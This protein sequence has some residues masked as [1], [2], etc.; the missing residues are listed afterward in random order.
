MANELSSSCPQANEL[1]D[2]EK[3]EGEISLDDVSSSEEGQPYNPSKG[4]ANCCPHCK[5][6]KTCA[7]WCGNLI[8]YHINIKKGA[9]L[10]G[11]ENRA[12]HQ[13][14]LKES[15]SFP[16]SIGKKSSQC[17][18]K[19]QKK[20]ASS[21]DASQKVANDG[22]VP[23]SSDSDLD[24]DELKHDETKK[25]SSSKKKHKKRRKKSDSPDV[26]I[27]LLVKESIHKLEPKKEPTKE[28]RSRPVAGRHHSPER[29]KPF[30]WHHTCPATS[31]PKRCPKSP[32][33]VQTSRK[34]CSPSR[35]RKSSRKSVSLSPTDASDELPPESPSSRGSVTRLLKKVRRLE[36]FSCKAGDKGSSLKDKLSGI[37][38]TETTEIAKAGN[39]DEDELVNNTKVSKDNDSSAEVV[40]IAYIV[41]S[42]PVEETVDE[43]YPIIEISKKNEVDKDEKAELPRP[44]KKEKTDLVVKA[45]TPL[46]PMPSVSTSSR[47]CSPLRPPDV[48]PPPS[49]SVKLPNFC[50]DDNEEDLELRMIALR[51]AVLKKH[52]TRMQ[53]S[54]MLKKS[55][56]QKIKSPFDSSF[57]QDFV[58]PADACYTGIMVDCQDD[59]YCPEDMDLD[60]DLELDKELL[61]M[62]QVELDWAPSPTDEIA[63]Q[64]LM[65]ENAMNAP[66]RVSTPKREYFVNQSL[67]SPTNPT[68]TPCSFKDFQNFERI[69]GP[70]LSKVTWDVS[71][72]GAND[73]NG[74][75]Y[76]LTNPTLRPYSPTDMTIY[77]PDLPGVHSTD[78]GSIGTS[79]SL[80]PPL[81]PPPMPPISIMDVEESIMLECPTNVLT[82]EFVKPMAPPPLP[83]P[84]LLDNFAVVSQQTLTPI[85]MTTPVLSFATPAVP[86]VPITSALVNDVSSP[87]SSL[88]ELLSG[89]TQTVSDPSLPLQKHDASVEC[90]FR[91]QLAISQQPMPIEADN[92]GET[93]LDGSPLVSMEKNTPHSSS[94]WPLFSETHCLSRNTLKVTPT[95]ADGAAPAFE[96]SSKK[97][98]NLVFECPS[99]LPTASKPKMSNIFKSTRVQGVPKKDVA[100]SPAAAFNG[101]AHDD[102]VEE[103]SD[104]QP[105][106]QSISERLKQLSKNKEQNLGAKLR[107]GKKRK[108][109]VVPR[110]PKVTIEKKRAASQSL[111]NA[112]M[113]LDQAHRRKE[114][115]SKSSEI[116]ECQQQQSDKEIEVENE[117]KKDIEDDEETL[118][119]Q[120]LA[121]LTKRLNK[122]VTT[123]VV[124]KV[125]EKCSVTTPAKSIIEKL[126]DSRTELAKMT[127]YSVATKRPMTNGITKNITSIIP[128]SIKRS[129]NAQRESLY[130]LAQQNLSAATKP[131]S[132]ITNTQD[133]SSETSLELMDSHVDQR[134]VINEPKEKIKKIE[135]SVEQ[136]L[137]NIRQQ[138]EEAAAKNISSPNQVSLSD[139]LKK[140]VTSNSNATDG[141]NA[142]VNQTIDLVSDATTASTADLS[143][144]TPVIFTNSSR[145]TTT[146]NSTIFT[147]ATAT[148]ATVRSS[149]EK[150]KITANDFEKLSLTATPQAVKHLPPSLQ[151]EYRRLKQQIIERERLKLQKAKEAATTTS[152]DSTFIVSASVTTTSAPLGSCKTPT[153]V[154][155]VSQVFTSST[156]TV[157][158]VSTTAKTNNTSISFFSSSSSLTPN[159]SPIFTLNPPVTST[160]L[161]KQVSLRQNTMISETPV[162]TAA[163]NN[164]LK[165]QVQV[166]ISTVNKLSMVEMSRKTSPRP[167]TATISK[168]MVDKNNLIN[169]VAS[170]SSRKLAPQ[171]QNCSG[172][173]NLSKE[174]AALLDKMNSVLNSQKKQIS[175]V[176]QKVSTLRILTKDQINLKTLQVPSKISKLKTCTPTDDSTK[177]SQNISTTVE[178]KSEHE[179]P[180]AKSAKE[181][182]ANVVDKSMKNQDSAHL[183]KAIN[184]QST[185]KNL[186]Q[187]TIDQS[188][189]MNA[190]PSTEKSTLGWT[191]FKDLVDDEVDSLF[192]LPVMKQKQLLTESEEKLI[193]KRHSV[194]DDITEMSGSL[195]QWEIERDLQNT[196]TQEIQKLREQL[197]MAEGKL[198]QQKEKVN[199]IQPKVSMYHEKINNGRKECFRLSKVC[200]SLGQTIFGPNYKVPTA[201]AELLNNRIK[202]VATHTQ[203]LKS[204]A[205]RSNLNRHPIPAKMKSSP[206]CR[207]NFSMKP[208]V[209]KSQNSHDSHLNK[210][211]IIDDV[212]NFVNDNLALIDKPNVSNINNPNQMKTESRTAKEIN[213][214]SLKENN[215]IIFDGKNNNSSTTLNN[216]NN[217]INESVEGV[218]TKKINGKVSMVTRRVNS[219]STDD[220]NS[221][222]LIQDIPRKI[223]SK[224]RSTFDNFTKS[225]T[226]CSNTN[227]KVRSGYALSNNSNSEY[228]VNIKINHPNL[229]NRI[230]DKKIFQN[231]TTNGVDN[232]KLPSN[233]SNND[234]HLNDVVDDNMEPVCSKERLSDE[235]ASVTILDENLESTSMTYAKNNQIDPSLSKTAGLN[236]MTENN[237][238]S[239]KSIIECTAD[240]SDSNN[241]NVISREKNVVN[242]VRNVIVNSETD[243]SAKIEHSTFLEEISL[244]MANTIQ[245]P[246]NIHVYDQKKPHNYNRILSKQIMGCNDEL[247]N[248]AVMKKNIVQPYESILKHL[249]EPRKKNIDGILCPYELIGTCNDED[250]QF[251][252]LSAS[253]CS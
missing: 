30:L 215:I 150:E 54:G 23:I 149:M 108:K 4:L 161:D 219:I 236:F 142:V 223:E 240:S 195:R 28:K 75:I 37:I 238:D 202:E 217:L 97:K 72:T 93:D 114:I 208:N 38:K 225:I 98:N 187:N 83:P 201:G 237:G 156:P 185:S 144:T 245:V 203:K 221:C 196:V 174:Q 51:S 226:S 119:A 157:T 127:A 9:G 55:G 3:E 194:L 130:R 224:S 180:F 96:D 100:I 106:L 14:Y 110:F 84:S 151:K 15:E 176:A 1:V 74:S 50:I 61:S 159:S 162:T 218:K 121:S 160:P 56:S 146:A 48:S 35:P 190:S 253:H 252:H 81:Q 64:S 95:A 228:P 163:V 131:Q 111:I 113:K 139:S 94:T 220:D 60:S 177:S 188:T 90:S 21:V 99:I 39:K 169:L 227:T 85:L 198:Q 43:N 44:P 172:I 13:H 138:Q 105:R 33:T 41:K 52:R 2:D 118:R 116:H 69:T 186:A 165:Q 189:S 34:K 10:Q 71:A 193:S 70:L 82:G 29:R 251:I 214:D 242:S 239:Q 32:P 247:K 250:C 88:A 140:N 86:M 120:L 183:I 78:E 170:A 175:A 87:A 65:L 184:N 192:D 46:P 18:N 22:L 152:V 68:T 63:D 222:I 89:A 76:E 191:K 36:P 101:P 134:V 102:M 27:A 7:T 178:E 207:K 92:F 243:S 153:K 244:K 129:R 230:K 158:T 209:Q 212:E 166:P 137:K 135:M 241:E 246:K 45:A 49:P 128:V 57:H 107:K 231:A 73:L 103:R 126:Q 145:N 6:V 233:E 211:A 125:Q 80:A 62:G 19:Y 20:T 167:S 40:E 115:I 66:E 133:L 117:T 141:S 59:I 248:Y 53:K 109:S 200:D 205:N 124:A 206:K 197:R 42:K 25:K 168:L 181:E 148:F 229:S 12:N 204:K 171:S 155:E 210:A 79:K 5:S 179:A 123:R 11:K 67:Y 249:H 112:E 17:I 31:R 58:G 143:S 132:K 154:V 26:D 182:S 173:N 8:T 164:S 24:L 216:A 213:G 147:P 136:F 122:T 234:S 232:E 199:A 104:Y 235:N 47:P 77:D 16:V 91:K